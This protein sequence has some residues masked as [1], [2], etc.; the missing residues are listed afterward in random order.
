M[1]SPDP[2][3]HHPPTTAS[4]QIKINTIV[5]VIITITT[6]IMAPI[7]L[8]FDRVATKDMPT[9]GMAKRLGSDKFSALSYP[10]FNI[11]CSQSNILN[12]NEAESTALDLTGRLA[13]SIGEYRD[14]LPPC[15]TITKAMI[16]GFSV[17]A[18]VS[19]LDS[20]LSLLPSLRDQNRSLITVPCVCLTV[21][22]LSPSVQGPLLDARRY[23]GD[24]S[25]RPD[26]IRL[27]H[28]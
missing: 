2:Y 5:V 15:Y 26:G 3:R 6:I 10:N 25:D 18:S 1:P 28:V 22:V 27:G 21:R 24:S 4:N 23:P 20:S 9:G 12:L 16:M 11:A 13:W 7:P 19:S 8:H 17:M 14:G